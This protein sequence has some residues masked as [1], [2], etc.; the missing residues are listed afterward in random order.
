MSTPAKIGQCSPSTVEDSRGGNAYIM[1]GC[2]E[3]STQ[4]LVHNVHTLLLWWRT[5]AKR[6][7]EEMARLQPC[8]LSQ[9]SA[10]RGA[11]TSRTGVSVNE[12]DRGAPV[13]PDMRERC[14]PL[15][16]AALWEKR[17]SSAVRF[18]GG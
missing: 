8:W 16:E 18:L 13:W 10:G 5:H 3:G 17:C 9:P 12:R 2:A 7:H 6:D 1:P 11:G 15:W 4:L 14:R